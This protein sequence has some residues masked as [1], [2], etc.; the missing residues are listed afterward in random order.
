MAGK[1]RAAG[2][3]E[4]AAPLVKRVRLEDSEEGST[5]ASSHA[6]EAS[7]AETSGTS[8][9][10]S[11]RPK[12]YV[13]EL[14]GCGKAF[15]RP[16]RLEA[17]I[18]THT[19]HRPLA[20][21]EEGCTKRFFKAEHLKAHIQNK[22]SDETNY[23]CT[24][25]LGV[26]EE[27]EEVRCGKSFTTGTRLRRHVAAHEQKEH[28]TC[29]E[30][31]CG[32]VFRK[33]ET[34]QRHIKK[35]H[36]KE[37]AFRCTALVTL[38][39]EVEELVGIEEEC[40]Q[41][42]ST[43]GQLKAHEKREHAGPK[44]FCDFCPKQ[45]AEEREQGDDIAA[46]MTEMHAPAFLT[47]ADLQTHIKAV[48][49]P[50]CSVCGKTQPSSRALAAH[51]DI[52]HGTQPLS[53]RQTFACD[54]TGCDRTF[55]RMGNL[56]VHV[57][58]VHVKNKK[59]VCGVFHLD[60]N[61]KVEGW[62]GHGCGLAFGTKANLES[63]VRTQHLDLP[64]LQH[65]PRKGRKRKVK[66]DD[67]ESPTPSLAE[68]DSPADFTSTPATP[69]NSYPT[70]LA[71]LTGRDYTSSRPYACWDHPHCGF[72]FVKEYDL[73]QHM[74]L[75]HG[76]NVDDINDH[77]AEVD[78]LEGE[79]FWVGGEVEEGLDEES[80][81]QPDDGTFDVVEDDDSEIGFATQG[82]EKLS[83]TREIESADVATLF[84]AARSMR[85]SM[86]GGEEEE[87]VVDPA[88]MGM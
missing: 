79:K 66:T 22:H 26:D 35:E 80:T 20:C 2:F 71:L 17:H 46:A 30:A 24:Y 73:A 16:V 36:L 39:V 15:D 27:G 49:P 7:V 62:D 75:T 33:L 28:T 19:D 10:S 5:L 51:M 12:K 45:E 56:K 34:L 31:G 84:P 32:Q 48:H 54:W 88:L 85:E 13:C 52:V 63:H 21:E 78:A 11:K 14:E 18:R 72:R 29:T 55:T 59:F 23:T 9:S 60:N 47:Y 87:V 64:D 3:P 81:Q 82:M 50:T 42:F 77:F 8:R 76:W 70:T 83:A 69:G 86:I 57:Q 1:K 25:V 58:T 40:G 44:Y 65:P 61:E 74:E 67:D 68:L 4:I 41:T 53:E 6:E 43:V 37:K 38:E